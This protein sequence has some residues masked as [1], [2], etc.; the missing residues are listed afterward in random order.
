MMV[1]YEVSKHLGVKEQLRES[2]HVQALGSL[3]SYYPTP[4]ARNGR[5]SGM[6]GGTRW[7]MSDLR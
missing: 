7:A 2:Y 1:T 3:T 6:S 4:G 5:G